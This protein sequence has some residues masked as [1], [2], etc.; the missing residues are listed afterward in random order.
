M[1]DTRQSGVALVTAM[2]ILLLLAALLAGFIMLVMTDQRLGTVDR[3]RTRALYAAHGGMEKLNADLGNLFL[4]NYAPT[5]AQINAL[6]AT[7]APTPGQLGWPVL[8]GI[9]FVDANLGGGPGTG[10][11]ITYTADPVTG[12]PQASYRTILSGPFQGFI[13]LI[14]PYTMTITAQTSVAAATQTGSEVRIRRTVQTVGIPV[15]QFGIFSETDLSFHAGPSFNFGG[16]THTNGNLFIAEG[17]N[18]VLTMSDRVTVVKEVVRTH[19]NN[20]VPITTS[21]HTGTVNVLRATG[22]Y[23]SLLSTEGSL[24]G[25]LG[26]AQ[27]EPT[28]TNLS[29][30]TYNGNIRNGRT[31]ARVLNLPLVTLGAQ[32][33]DLIRRPVPGEDVSNPNI[34]AQRYFTHNIGDQFTSLRILLSDS[35]AEI[36]SLPTVTPTP[37]VRLGNLALNPITGYTIGA[38]IPGAGGILPPFALSNGNTAQGYA[39]PSSTPLIDGYL[40]IE[41]MTTAGAW[42]DVTLEIL[43]LGVAGRNL[44]TGVLNT[45][46]TTCAEP[47]PNAVIRF[48]RLRDVPTSFTPCGNGSINANDYWPNVL[49]DTR[50]GNLRDNI[51][52]TQTTMFLGGVMHYIELDVNNLRRWFQGAIGTSGA[53][54]FSLNG[55]VIY[56]SDRRGNKNASNV[57]TG[58]YGFED[59][60]NPLSSTSI[61]PSGSLDTGEDVNLNTVL[62]TYGQN[63]IV[64]TGAL[65]P[66]VSTARPWTV[67]GITSAVARVNRPIFFRR[68]LKLVNGRLGNI[69]TPGLTVVSENPVYIQGD[70]NATSTGAGFGNPHVAASVIADAVTLLSNN[71]NDIRSFTAPHAPGS[72]A[73][74][75]TWYRLAIISGKGM[76]FPKPTAFATYMDM[77]SDGGVHNFLRMIESWSGQTLNYRGSIVS[78]YYNRQG[79]GVF[80]CCTNVYSPPT[81][82]FNF[83]TDFLTPSLLPPR[84]PMFRDINVTGFTQLIMPWQ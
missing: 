67:T 56:F 26:S 9:N 75:T 17:A 18:N 65:T 8:P 11:R 50:E 41:M 52:T 37:P 32:P 20:G 44:S 74:T 71:W 36:T 53:S 66:L 7:Q 81:R 80:K 61:P 15:F 25:T 28:W 13:G 6:T 43:N 78:F 16:R 69:V 22:V 76:N 58:E 30:G 57:E 31:G 33:I 79:N 5:A 63:P 77:G 14:T 73:A 1:K 12:N 54:A 60:V 35:P 68:A 49:Y 70:Y 27:N 72:R 4:I 39:S 83:D 55:Y 42:Q 45:P 46:G 19:M 40:K 29:I 24:V 47:N 23:R 64:P 84:T 48:Q 21:G 38:A 59:F 51:A 82:A 10:Y 2:I 3:D 62:D 34:Y